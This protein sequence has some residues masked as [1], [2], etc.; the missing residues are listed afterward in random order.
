MSSPK[1]IAT[2]EFARGVP[3]YFP[4]RTILKGTMA[5]AAVGIFSACAADESSGDGGGSS[6]TK[7]TL[8]EAAAAMPVTLAMD[9]GRG[10]GYEGFEVWQLVQANLIRNPYVEDPDDPN[11]L[12]QDLYN[13]EGELAESYDVSEDGLTYTFHLTPDV[14]SQ[15]GNTLSADDVLW[16]FE[17]KFNTPNISSYLFNPSITDPARQIT[18]VD[19]LTVAIQLDNAGHGFP[20]LAVITKLAGHI[21]DS[22][23]LLE[24]ATADDPY[25][26]EYSN[27]ESLGNFGYGPYKITAYEDGN[28]IVY[29]AHEGYVKGEPPLKKI[30][31]RVVPEASNRSALLK[32]GDVDVAVQL[33]PADVADMRE[34]KSIR[35]FENATNNFTWLLM[36]VDSDVFADQLV[37]QAF[38]KAIPYDQI[39]ET[40]YHG[41]GKPAR[42]W[43]DPSAPGYNGEGIPEQVYDPEGA[44]ALLEQAG[45]STPVTFSIM[46]S[47]AVPDLQ[48]VAVQMQSF[49]TD[50][51]FDIKVDV[52]PAT[53]DA[54]R[55]NS[56]DYEACLMRDMVVSWE[57]QT[58]TLR[59]L[60]GTGPNDPGNWTG[61]AP[62][63][64]MAEIDAGVDAGDA[65]SDEAG[66]H[67][68][69]A[70]MMLMEGCTLIQVCNVTPL[71]AHRDNVNPYT[72]RSDNVYEFSRVEKT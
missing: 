34:D 36:N 19:D 25:A 7:T 3:L 30:V 48:E 54:D 33:L 20:M 67:W 53:T 35:T 24:H 56:R 11:V 32:A 70:H 5:A 23:L 38:F 49:G 39:I 16:S 21:Y 14:V 26:L 28:Q 66:E 62:P 41:A 59:L 68:H 6:S 22:K 27:T 12:V 31:M 40:V 63:E 72:Q 52:V 4:R 37:R 64:F 8:V 2:P 44:L 10:V 61:W 13:W 9:T 18:K 15:A 43:M 29:E 45:V 50:A 17:R 58:Y 55:K 47:S 46:C 71:M 69:N 42:G 60:R 51:G 57:S 1:R 65:F